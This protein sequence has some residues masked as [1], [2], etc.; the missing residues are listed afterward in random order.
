MESDCGFT[1]GQADGH[2]RTY[3]SDALVATI[4]STGDEATIPP[5]SNRNTQRSIDW[6]RY[7]ARNL[8][9]R[10]FNRLKQFR[11]LATRYDKLA[12]RFNPFL[13]LACAY[14]WLL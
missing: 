3:D 9:A 7:E 14:T 2:R 10:F 11:R 5:R 6:H 1:A 12:D 8:V 13:H 4:E